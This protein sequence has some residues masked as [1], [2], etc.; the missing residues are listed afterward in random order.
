MSLSCF[1]PQSVQVK[2]A[3]VNNFEEHL[4][5]GLRDLK[6]KKDYWST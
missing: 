6:K 3:D 4:E 1:F 5:N 2:T